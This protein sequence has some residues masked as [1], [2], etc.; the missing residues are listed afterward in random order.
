MISLFLKDSV[1]LKNTKKRRRRRTK[2]KK[3]NKELVKKN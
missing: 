3:R 2:L 1:P